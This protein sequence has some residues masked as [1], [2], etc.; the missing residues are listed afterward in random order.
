[1]YRFKFAVFGDAWYFAMRKLM[2]ESR[3]HGIVV[4]AATFAEYMRHDE[5]GEGRLRFF[6]LDFELFRGNSF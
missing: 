3:D 4:R 2:A 6:G 1:M 5:I